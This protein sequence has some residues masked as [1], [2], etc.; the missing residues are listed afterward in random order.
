VHPLNHMFEKRT[1][2][3]PEVVPVLK[4]MVLTPATIRITQITTTTAQAMADQMANFLA[5]TEAS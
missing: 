2:Q 4:L 3:N 5:L 1:G